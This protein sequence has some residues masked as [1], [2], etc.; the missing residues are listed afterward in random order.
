MP[1]HALAENW[2]GAF[3][4][5][6]LLT[7]LSRWPTLLPD[8]T[9]QAVLTKP[10]PEGPATEIVMGRRPERVSIVVVTH[11]NLVFTRLCLETVLFNTGQADYELI[12]VDNASDD[13]T[14]EYLRSLAQRCPLVRVLVN[15]RNL[16][17]ASALNQGLATARGDVF[18]LL[19]NDTIVPPGWLEPLLKHVRDPGV[20]MVG[21][22]TNRAG[23][24]AQIE[25]SYRTY[26]E[27]VRFA[28][29][30]SQAHPER[31]FDIRVVTMF[32][33]VLTRDT[34][35]RVGPL[36]ERFAVGLFED[37][38]YAIRLRAA[39]CR[40]IC[41]EDVF[42]HHFG[43]ASLGRL[44][45]DG[46]YGRVFHENRRRWEDK[47]GVPWQPYER[48][49]KPD[50]E[51]L[52]GRIRELVETVVP[53]EGRVLVVS[54]GDDDLLDLNG[55]TAWHFP[56]AANGGYSGCNPP[57]GPAAIAHLAEL[58]ARG[59]DFLL[60]PN[61]ALWWLDYYTGLKQHLEEEHRWLAC[62]GDICL[63]VQLGRSA[64]ETEA[65]T[66]I[67]DASVLSER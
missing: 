48:R 61:T 3:P 4:P 47:W 62:E 10:L 55:R 63:I 66:C 49:L 28:R 30:H 9:V 42:V 20:G 37:D 44:A 41:A 51:R 36:D 29:E 34:Y 52:K 7:P 56:Q 50:Y 5:G 13:D 64:A 18:V 21:P 53:R 17:F 12:V 54:K 67:A 57:D 23:N 65:S 6:L 38:D 39:G 32:C 1:A 46:E 25:V 27:F 16:G 14:P 33:A 31:N 22:V 59:A 11:N 60:I 58:R 2:N 43:Q 45:R 24:E 35:E 19:N 26:G 8:E 40:V 15:R